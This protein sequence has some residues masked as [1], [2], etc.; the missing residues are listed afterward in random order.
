MNI[1]YVHVLYAFVKS[2]VPISSEWTASFCK[3]V[4]FADL[5]IISIKELQYVVVFMAI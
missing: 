4:T 1:K 3:S 2:D 5:L